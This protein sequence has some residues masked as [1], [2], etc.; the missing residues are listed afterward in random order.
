MKR[1]NSFEDVVIPLPLSLAKIV[2]G[3]TTSRSE[4]VELSAWAYFRNDEIPQASRAFDNCPN[5]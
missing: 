5:I 4:M 1:Q 3:H 2:P